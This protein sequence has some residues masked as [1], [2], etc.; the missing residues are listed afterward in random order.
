MGTVWSAMAEEQY[1]RY[2]M[3]IVF[4]FFD[5]GFDDCCGQLITCGF[6][7]TRWFA[8][9]VIYSFLCCSLY[10]PLDSCLTS[11]MRSFFFY[12]TCKGTY[13]SN[14][15]VTSAFVSLSHLVVIQLDV[16]LVFRP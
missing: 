14:I 12:Y 15:T 2:W 4:S 3:F 5:L 6:S 8:D 16:N 13:R 11:V 9:L 1:V 10:I 7:T